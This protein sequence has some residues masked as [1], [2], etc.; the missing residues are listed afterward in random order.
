MRKYIFI[1]LLGFASINTFSQSTISG[2][3]SGADGSLPIARVYLEGTYD[4]ASTNANG[5]F[6]F[7]T[8]KTGKVILKASFV[9]FEP[10]SMELNLTVSTVNLEIALKEAFD[11]LNAIT[12]TAGTF[13]TVDKKRAN[14]LT[15]LDMIT[16]AGAVGDVYGALQTLPGSGSWQPHQV[17]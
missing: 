11:V 9:G 16:T 12:I 7:R 3:V 2:K 6:S 1:F 13:E 14:I 15:P 5:E 8:S 10:F 4:G 17:L